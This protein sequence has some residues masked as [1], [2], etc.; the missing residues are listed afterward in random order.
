[1][2]DLE[3]FQAWSEE[4][5]EKMSLTNPLLYEV[6]EEIASSKQP[7]EEGN[8]HEASQIIMEEK[9]RSRVLRASF[10]AEETHQL[11]MDE[12]RSK[13][14]N[15]LKTENEGRQLG[16]LL[17]QTTQGETQ[18][19]VTRWLSATN[20]WEAWRQLNLSIHFKLLTNL[21]KTEFDDQPASC[22]QQFIAW[23]EQVG[24]HQRLSREQLPDSIKLSAVVN[25]LKGR[26]K[27]FVLLNLNGDSNFSDLDN[28]L[29]LYV[30][31][32]DQHEFSLESPKNRACRDKPEREVR[33]ECTEGRGKGEAYPPQPTTQ[34]GNGKPDQLPRRKQWCS[35]C[36]KKGHRTQACWWNS[37]QQHRQQQARAA[38]HQSSQQQQG[39]AQTSRKSLKPTTTPMGNLEHEPLT[40]SFEPQTRATTQPAPT[41]PAS[42]IAQL[43]SSDHVS[44][45]A[46]AWG[47]LV[48]TGAATSVAPK[49]FASDIELSP[50]SSTL[51]LTT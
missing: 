13:E 28:L 8:I 22:L 44:S 2:D 45:P 4:I 29:A 42:I 34:T 1:M 19:Q 47:V 14:A 6:L 17:V 39:T 20:G 40:A 25:G 7:I 11:Q 3:S 33:K 24:I 50:A 21:M 9:Q 26:V 48:D 35:L 15:K 43:E 30:S 18:L 10:K 32:H 27:S 49:G 31:M 46:E 51:Q 41:L 36:W 23:K 16:C 5:K 12:T 38:R 37:N